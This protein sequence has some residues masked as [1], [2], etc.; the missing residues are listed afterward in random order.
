MI[1]GQRLSYLTYLGRLRSLPARRMLE[2]VRGGQYPQS[3]VAAMLLS[4]DA[5]ADGDDTRLCGPV[6]GL[7]SVLS[8][9]G[10][11]RGLLHAAGRTGLP[12]SGVVD[13]QAI[14]AAVGALAGVSLVTFT[15]DGSGL[16]AHRLVMRVIRERLQETGELAATCMAFLALAYRDAGRIGEAVRLLE[17]NVE[18]SERILG[19]DHPETLQSVNSLAFAYRDAGRISEATTMHQRALATHVRVL[20]PDHPDTIKSRTNLANARHRP[21]RRD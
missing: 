18:A 1:S 17:R 5:L 16:I 14:D 7:L 13:E 8:P 19:S 12:G 3:V 21:S 20:G 15:V 10:T 6:M 2:P 4:L 11:A 9:A